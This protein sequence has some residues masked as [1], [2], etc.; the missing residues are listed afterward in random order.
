MSDTRAVENA[1]PELL[2][3]LYDRLPWSA[4]APFAV[5]AKRHGVTL[6]L[7]DDAHERALRA[8][9]DHWVEL[10]GGRS[11]DAELLLALQPDRAVQFTAVM[12][13]ETVMGQL[14]TMPDLTYRPLWV[15]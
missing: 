15:A 8:L 6:R 3:A 7:D 13:A 5:A 2:D 14:A 1:S 11:V 9:A 4:L 12:V 10:A